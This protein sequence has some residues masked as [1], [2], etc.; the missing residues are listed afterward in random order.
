MEKTSTEKSRVHMGLNSHH[1]EQSVLFYEAF[2][3]VKPVKVQPGY[4]KFELDEP[5]LNL[6]LT[7]VDHAN[8]NQVS[9]FGVQVNSSQAVRAQA[10]R[11]KRLELDPWVEEDT[12]C[13]YSRQDKVWV[14]DPDGNA[15]ETFVVH[16]DV[17]EKACDPQEPAGCSC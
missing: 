7:Q 3:A 8:G 13:C 17:E 16:E 14:R 12:V 2:F 15:W 11:L 6:A 4:A 1:F 10:E 9:H 5:P